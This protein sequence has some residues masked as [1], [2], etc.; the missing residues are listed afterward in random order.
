VILE[1]GD[2]PNGDE[3]FYPDADIEAIMG[4]NGQ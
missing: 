1:V 4:D 3:V 2:R